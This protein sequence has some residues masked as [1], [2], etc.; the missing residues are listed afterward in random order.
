MKRWSGPRR[1]GST[2]GRWPA[3]GW[4]SK[5]SVPMKGRLRRL[6]VFRFKTGWRADVTLLLKPDRS[7]PTTKLLSIMY[8][9]NDLCIIIPRIIF[10]KH[11]TCLALQSSHQHN[12]NNGD[13]G[14]AHSVQI[15]F[16]FLHS[17]KY[18]ICFDLPIRVCKINT[19]D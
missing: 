6:K 4:S 18:F 8:S 11:R 12:N 15:T 3:E 10:K 16:Q 13:G 5:R 17:F 7:P 9:K 2:Y 1:S 14:A 19:T